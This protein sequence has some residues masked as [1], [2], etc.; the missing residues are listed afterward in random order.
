MST[1]KVQFESGEI[2][3]SDLQEA[4]ERFEEADIEQA[5]GDGIICGPYAIA[6]D[7]GQ[8]STVMIM[9]VDTDAFKEFM[10]FEELKE[11]VEDGEDLE[12]FKEAFIEAAGGEDVFTYVEVADAGLHDG[13]V[14]A[15]AGS[16]LLNVEHST[17]V[18]GYENPL[19]VAEVDGRELRY[20][21]TVPED[22]YNDYNGLDGEEV[23][24]SVFCF[25][26]GKQ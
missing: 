2:P 16:E 21:G 9:N 26:Y 25:L 24:S 5:S 3:K 14:Y 22:N 11:K 18:K 6:D 10:P 1:E 12:S 15:Y 4:I 7:F 19:D 17:N 8:D 20:F 23:P 13:D